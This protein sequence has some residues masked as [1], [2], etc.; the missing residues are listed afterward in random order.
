MISEYKVVVLLVIFLVLFNM[1][2]LYTDI[3]DVKVF[4]TWIDII[5]VLLLIIIFSRT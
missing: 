5:C 1:Y 4:L 2:G 3:S